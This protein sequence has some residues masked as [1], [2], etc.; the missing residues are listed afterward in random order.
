M[1]HHVATRHPRAAPEGTFTLALRCY[2]PR[3]EIA[4]GEWVPPPV[5]RVARQTRR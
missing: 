2:S 4:I 3:F 5:K 1:L